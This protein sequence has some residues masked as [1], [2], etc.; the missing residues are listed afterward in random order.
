SVFIDD[1]HSRANPNWPLTA[2]V[3]DM[4]SGPVPGIFD[5]IYSLD[6]LE[7][8]KPADEDVFM[9][10]LVASL[11]PKGGAAIIGMPSL[12]SQVYASPQSKAGHVNCKTGPEL[13][14]F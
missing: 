8:I 3:H 4:L 12:E 11:K 5:G 1:V 6:V 7:H 14:K 13:K 9:K 2:F 10:N